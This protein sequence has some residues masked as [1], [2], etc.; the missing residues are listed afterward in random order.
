MRRISLLVFGVA[1]VSLSL[2]TSAFAGMSFTDP[3]GDAADAPDV[4][5]V[6]V[7][8]DIGG[9]I[10]FHV[11]VANFTPES[12]IVLYLDTDK[13][14]ST[15]EDGAD[16]LLGLDHSTDP[17]SEG[18]VLLQWNGTEWADAAQHSTVAAASDSTFADF[19]INK[20]DLGGTSGFA[21]QVWTR[22]YVAG[23]VTAR[24]FA[25]DGSLSTWTYDLVAPKPAPTPTV[26]K[27]VFGA[28]KIVPAKPVAGKKLVF[29]V[30]VKRSDTGAPLTAGTMSCDP[31]VAGKVIKHAESFSGGKAK[32]AFVVPK[33]AK[34]KL[35]KVKVRIV[36]G[37]QAATKVATYKVA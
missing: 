28:A 7:S 34:G 23:A 25:P 9:N 22:R 5:A 36:N 16:F 18:W 1:L 32:L 15:G 3:A 2:L 6:T 24:D 30:A 29:T 26:V 35:L 12:R 33:T 27:P 8:N 20:S 17:A 4:T 14:A 10:M 19:R 13:N 11:A 37:A 21:F 31:S